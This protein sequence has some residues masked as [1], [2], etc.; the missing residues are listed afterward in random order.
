M[1]YTVLNV[2]LLL[3][4]VYRT[5]GLGNKSFLLNLTSMNLTRH[6]LLRRKELG[7]VSI[8]TPFLFVVS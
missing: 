2:K 3:L 8:K 1:L 6:T 5:V 4:S 7:A